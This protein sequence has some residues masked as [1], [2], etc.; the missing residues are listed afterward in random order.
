[1]FPPAGVSEVIAL[2]GPQGWRQGS[3]GHLG[4]VSARRPH[5]L[6]G[7][8]RRCCEP[9]WPSR[10]LHYLT[11]LRVHLL[12]EEASPFHRWEVEAQRMPWLGP[13]P[14]GSR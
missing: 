7:A 11:N 6:G 13:H 5:H 3:L 12:G 1:M 8:Q 9:G 4:L 14:T 10:F 2:V